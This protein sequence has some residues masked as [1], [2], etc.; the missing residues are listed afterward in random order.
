[1]SPV[2]ITHQAGLRHQAPPNHPECPARYQAVMD[3]ISNLSPQWQQIEAPKIAYDRLALVHEKGHL[4]WLFNQLETCSGHDDLLVNLDGNTYVGPDSLEAALRG[5]GAACLAVDKVMEGSARTAFSAMRPPGHHAEPAKAMGFCL[6]SNAAIAARHAQDK[7]GAERVSVLDFDVHHGNGTQAAFWNHKDLF[8]ASS[9]QMPLYPGTGAID[10]VGATGN[11]FNLPLSEGDGGATF[12]AGWRDILLP[13]IE[14]AGCDL[15]IISAGFDAHRRDPL[16]GL[17]VD[18]DDF[19]ALTR[20]I[21][22]LADKISAGRIISL[23]EGGYDLPALTQSTQAH[24]NVLA[25]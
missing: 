11:I 17:T 8:Y 13:K 9:H 23:L 15:M 3:A 4:D 12:L 7:W 2:I 25:S 5:A 6:F 22:T 10:E 21:A 24:L 18:T 20:D 16:G 19:A 1:M 14:A